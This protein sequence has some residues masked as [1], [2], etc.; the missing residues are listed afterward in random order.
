MGEPHGRHPSISVS[1]NRSR[2]YF[3]WVRIIP[4][5][6]LAISIPRKYRSG[7]NPLPQRLYLASLLVS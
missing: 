3:L 7:P 1:A 6:G 2:V 4:L 5:D